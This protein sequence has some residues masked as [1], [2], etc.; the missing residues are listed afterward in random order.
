MDEYYI[1]D[2]K[3]AFEQAL[4]RM[5]YDTDKPKKVHL[6]LTKK[7]YESDPEWWHD[8]LRRRGLSDDTIVIVPSVFDTKG[9]VNK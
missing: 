8:V 5:P 3:R 4:A 6:F 2:M 7:Q 9:D 1:Q